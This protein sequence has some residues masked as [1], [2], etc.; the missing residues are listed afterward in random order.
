MRQM[1][2]VTRAFPALA[3]VILAVAPEAE[4]DAAGY[5]RQVGEAQK[6]RR[7]VERSLG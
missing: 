2:R 3:F 1:A 6:R 5:D 4:I 7:S